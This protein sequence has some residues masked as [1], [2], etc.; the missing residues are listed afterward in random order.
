MNNAGIIKR[1]RTLKDIEVEKA[2]LRYQMLIA[3]RDILIA[4]RRAGITLPITATLSKIERSA[5]YVIK[6]ITFTGT[7]LKKLFGRDK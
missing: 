5:S 2:R 4:F 7:F 3:E 1:I 6:G